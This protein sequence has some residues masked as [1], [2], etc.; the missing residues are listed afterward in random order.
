MRLDRI[1]DVLNQK[2]E[3]YK[4]ECK[5]QEDEREF[6]VRQLVAIKKENSRLRRE[7]EKIK[8][9]SENLSMQDSRYVP[10]LCHEHFC[11]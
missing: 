4:Q 8:S 9:V 11:F 2:L 1:N 3:K 6:L 10:G 5:M 7:I